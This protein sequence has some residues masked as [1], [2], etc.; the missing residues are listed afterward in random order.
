MNSFWQLLQK[1]KISTRDW[2]AL[3]VFFILLTLMGLY[4]PQLMNQI[5]TTQEPSEYN[6]LLFIL[7]LLYLAQY[8]FR[9]I[10][11][12]YFSYLSKNA[13]G[14]Y[15]EEVF[16]QWIFDRSTWDGTV[17]ID[18]YSVGEIQARLLTDTNSLKEAVDNGSLTILFDFILVFAC[19]ISFILIDIRVGLSFFLLQCI[20]VMSLLKISK[21]L[22]PIF[23]EVRKS[24][25]FL[26]KD[27]TD[28]L[29]GLSQIFRLNQKDYALNRMKSVQD[30]YLKVQLNANFY[31]AS[32]FA[33]AESLFPLFLAFLVMIFPMSIG[34][35]LALLAVLIDLIQRSVM[36]MKDL[37]NKISTLQRVFTGIERVSEFQKDLRPIDVLANNSTN[38]MSFHSIEFS[39]AKFSYDRGD[40]LLDDAKREQFS[41][42]PITFRVKKGES[43]GIAGR[44]GAGKTTVVKIATLQ[45]YSPHSKIRFFIDNENIKDVHFSNHDD[46]IFYAQQVCIVSQESHLF[47][48]SIFFNITLSHQISDSFLAFWDQMIELIPYLKH[49]NISPLTRIIPKEL[50]YGQ[51]Q[52][53]GALR[54]IY[55]KKPIIVFDEI[56]A[57]MDKELENSLY[58]LLVIMTVESLTIIVAH[59]LETIKRCNSIL[60]MDQGKVQ[61]FGTHQELMQ[62]SSLYAEYLKEAEEI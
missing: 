16:R 47:S 33:F 62:R 42:E 3:I 37:A 48:T 44:S 41:L 14:A 6:R 34:K 49:W 26:T 15:R 57:G 35:N 29:K 20:V 45:L 7:C 4:L 11:Q 12:A 8:I 31:D 18:K 59:R 10:Y 43:I 38:D 22:A 5:F 28:I 46:L 19:S 61:D 56:S 25:S 27:L 30:N 50:S 24:Y 9:I 53:L 2:I 54:A 40:L 51:R 39:I 58:R 36:P 21:S 52:L 32:Y 60:L 17:A 23:H 55:L 13:I 1:A